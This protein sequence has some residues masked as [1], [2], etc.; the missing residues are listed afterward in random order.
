MLNKIICCVTLFFVCNVVYSQTNYNGWNIYTSF[1]EVKGVSLGGANVWAASSGGLF[2]FETGNTSNIEKYIS[3]DGLRS[4]ELTAVSYSN[5]G[6][7]WAGAFDGSISVLNTN[8][9]TWRQITD[10]NSSTEPSKKIN[11]FYQ[12]GNLMFFGSEFC[13]VKFNISQFQFV[14]QPYTRFGNLAVP[15]AVYDILVV[16]DTIWAATKNG[17]A[18]ANINTNLPIQTNWQTFTTSNPVMRDNLSNCLV[19][20]DSKVFIGTDSGMVYFENGTLNSFA[21]QY[22]GFPLEDPVYRMAVSGDVLYFSAYTNYDGYRG[23]YR[24][25]RVSRQNL[26]N[27]ELVQSG[28]E[29][30]SLKVNASGD[31]LIGTVTNGVE[32]FRNNTAQFVFPNGPA[33]NVFQDVA[34][35]IGGNVYGVSGG[36]NAGVY[37]YNFTNWKNFNTTEQ[38]WIY[39]ND[40]RHI[41]ASKYSGKVWAGGFGSGLVQIDGDSIVS[42]NSSNSCLRPLDESGFTLVEGMGEDNAGNFWLINRASDAGLPILKFSTTIP[43]QGYPTPT[44][45]SA[46]T[47]IYM[48]IDNFNTKW[49]TFPSDL[50]GQPRGIAY[51]NE[52][53][54]PNGLIINAPSLGA[55]MTTVYHAVTDKAGE[56]WIATDNGISIIRN[57]QQI[58]NNPGTIPQT[59]KMRIIENGISTP[60]TENIQFICV[61]PLNNKWIGTLSNGLLYVSSDGSTLLARYNT[62]NSPLPTN[63]I[64][65]I[66]VSTLTGTVFFGTEKGLVSL[67]TIAAQ[68]LET[69][70]KI[71]TGPNPFIIP[72]ET[73]LRIDGL[74]SESIVKIMTLSG[75]LVA[76]FDSPGGRIAEWDGRDLN[77]NLVSS[78]IYIIA[79]YNKDASQVCTGKVA[80]LKR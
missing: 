56:V 17:I 69:C 48:T 36:L 20:F 63:K 11:S 75:T 10:I 22:N 18:Y 4:N 71:K 51:F 79:G 54:S 49:L 67:K 44:S 15:N 27:A 26:S 35:D 39:G 5:D 70:D 80:V 37:R 32:V 9:N 8:D 76:E 24:I 73:K 68:S 13:I 43:C 64:T 74:V 50:P 53:I 1:R 45:P 40:Y 46:T 61:D 6:N 29:V 47:M 72:S 66:V 42:Y 34:V 58:I 38:P 33:S 12:Y 62:A 19:S 65:S 59:E 41:Y 78:G 55:D 2:S 21:P 77:G 25:F 28:T 16:N 3:L 31:L 60:L 14:D 7:V 23:N 52:G 30:N 57:P